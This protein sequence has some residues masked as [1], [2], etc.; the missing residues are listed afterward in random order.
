MKLLQKLPVLLYLSNHRAVRA[1]AVNA[2][3]CE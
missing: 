2:A 3:S 1:A